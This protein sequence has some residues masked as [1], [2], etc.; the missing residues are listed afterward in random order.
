M[1]EPELKK[2]YKEQVV[3]ALKQ[4]LKLENVHEI[5]RIEKV[6]LN[7]SVGATDAKAQIQKL[8]EDLAKISGQKALVTKAKKS[9]SNFKLREGMAI[10]V[11]VTLRG[12][13]MYDFLL[14]L[15]AI[16][17]P[18]IRDFRG[19]DNRFDGKGNVTI[20]IEDHTIFPEVSTDISNTQRFGLD[21]TIV[22]TADNDFRGFELLKQLGF[23]VRRKVTEVQ[24]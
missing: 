1:N 18:G 4:A 6:V 17:L 9:I 5:P 3:P 11:K 7:S 20:G 12:T 14:R 16:A 22:T 23:P 8:E 19:L 2:F 21:I 15:V 13:R 24:E 10:G